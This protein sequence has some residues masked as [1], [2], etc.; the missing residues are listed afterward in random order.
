MIKGSLPANAYLLSFFLFLVGQAS[1]A[2]FTASIIS[3]IHNFSLKHRGKVSGAL[4]GL[5]ATS[6]GVF[7]IIYRHTFSKTHDVQGYLLFLAILCSTIAFI[8]AFLIRFIGPKV[9]DSV[10]KQSGSGSELEEVS[11][12]VK[13]DEKEKQ[14]N[15][16]EKD[17]TDEETKE[18]SL[19]SRSNPNYL[20]GK[21]DITGLQLLKTEEFWLLF[22]IYFFVA[23]TCLMFLN[24]IGSVGKANGKSS[25]LRT[26]LVIVFAA[27]NLTGR[28]SFGL[29]SDLFSRKISRFWFLAISAT[30]IS[31]THLLYA[32]FTSDFYILATIL[33]G[34]GYGGLVSTMVLLTSVRFGVRRFGLNFGMLA[35]ASA[36]GSLSF[37]FLSGKLYD[38]HADEED[39]CYGEKCFR[40][41]FILSAV[42]NAMC[43]GVI[44]FL[45][46]RS[47]RHTY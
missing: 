26:D 43:I 13:V 34:V 9:P 5:F 30:I 28:S 10:I 39:E 6:S 20:D 47:K 31:I 38:D 44:L 12:T 40:T 22:I 27:C 46:H 35:I 4:V 3:N 37:G 23:G 1:H 32:F 2:S 17:N 16:L 8:G 11:D 24:N 19:E 29:L 7:G 25:D 42:F 41:A 45:I 15:L 14:Y 21:R 36:A 33:T 18:Y